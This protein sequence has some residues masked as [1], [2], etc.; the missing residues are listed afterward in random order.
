MTEN[1]GVPSS[2]LG[3]AIKQGPASG[4][5]F[6]EIHPVSHPLRH[7]DHVDCDA[8]GLATSLLSPPRA[9][10]RLPRALARETHE[11]IADAVVRAADVVTTMGGGDARPPYPSRRYLDWGL[12][13]PVGRDLDHGATAPGRA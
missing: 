5:A 13:D 8:G 1:R 6:G 12:G 2:S 7:V 4:G 11:R 9:G 3:L 10:N